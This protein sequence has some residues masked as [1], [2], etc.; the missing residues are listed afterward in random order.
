MPHARCRNLAIAL[1]ACSSA[2][3][4]FTLLGPVGVSSEGERLAL[5]GSKQ[6]ALLALLL[7]SANEVVSR[8]RLID[9]LWGEHAP[10][11]AQRS[12]DS[13]VSRLRTVVGAGRIVR[14]TPGYSIRVDAGELDLVDF[15]ALADSGRAASSKGDERTARELF[16]RALGIWSG[17]AL[18]N[19]LDEPFAGGEAERLEEA[20]SRVLE[21]R[22]RVDLD[23]GAAAEV[24]PELE[25]LV[26]AHPFREQLVLQ[27]MLALYRCGRQ[28]DALDAYQQCRRRLSDE[29]GLEPMPEL[30]ELQRRILQQDRNLAVP[31]RVLRRTMP[32][33]RVSRRRVSIAVG[34]LVAVALTVGAAVAVISSAT[35]PSS[36]RTVVESSQVAGLNPASGAVENRGVVGG[37]P[38]AMASGAGYVWLADP[39]AG[40]VSRFDPASRSV[41]DSVPVGG[42]PSTVAVGGGSVWTSSVPGNSVTRIDPA[43]GRITQRISLGSITISHLAFG[44]GGVWVGDL[45]D[46]SLIEIDPRSGEVRRTVE[47][48]LRPT[49]FGIDG[50]GIWVADYD[51]GSIARVDR[52]SGRVLATIRVGNGP[53]AFAFADRAVWVVNA[54][55]STVSRVDPQIGAVVA[56]I[57]VGSEP[58]AIVAIREKVLVANGNSGT[59]SVIDPRRNAVMRTAQLGGQPTAL[60]LAGGRA[61]VGVKPS[62]GRS[63]G[64]L[65]LVHQRPITIDPAL[66]EDLLP[67]VTDGLT[68]DGLVGFNLAPGPAGLQIV[69]DLAVTVP[70][71]TDGGRIYTFQLRPG[72]RYS[73]GRALRAADVRRAIERVFR[74]GSDNRVLFAAI[75]GARRCNVTLCDLSQGI[76]T[77]ERLRTVTFRLE[78]AD[79]DFLWKLASGAASTPVPPGT[80]DRAVGYDEPIPSTGP[81]RIASASAS[82]IRYVRNPLFKEWSHAAQPDGNPDEIV[83]RFGLTPAE[84]A[85]AIEDGRADWMADNIP[86]RLL[87][88]LRVRLPAQLH[89]F[90]IPTTDFF[91]FNATLPPFDDV[92]VRRALNLAI[93][94][95]AIARLYGGSDLATPT[96]QILAPGMTGY[97]AYCPYVG[98]SPTDRGWGPDLAKA[99]RLVAASAT[100]GTPV[101]VWGWTDDPTIRPSVTRYVAQTLRRLGYPTRVHLVPHAGL[102]STDVPRI[103]IIPTGWGRDTPYG[104]FT[105]WFTCAGDANHGW[106]C[107]R[108]IERRIELARSLA[109]T[110]PRAAA[111]AWAKIDR[112]LVDIAAALP[113]VNEHGVDFVSARVRNYQ[114]HPY[115]GVIASQL[116]LH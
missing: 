111:D 14:R 72:I 104:F 26:A 28:A 60:A 99:R 10:D 31:S 41:K 107:D 34:A 30:P 103:Q 39:S 64:T 82:E 93:D 46:S 63:G 52:R 105:R 57:P 106:L 19:V 68:R 62:A 69:P 56:T 42:A 51:V 48:P 115:Q 38:V 1:H 100:A 17:R 54:L 101:T 13:Y 76:V 112:R 50:G 110:D 11:G 84:Q 114:A 66:Q 35:G 44:G 15:R 116:S 53:A 70:V 9:G 33:V 29:L 98:R 12:L 5:G 3:V 95:R 6:H 97:R 67:L 22:I 71:T 83:M 61:W 92:R 75:R 32:P 20:R 7:L 47:L 16:G 96:C 87:P 73:D 55:D 79:P 37:A 88:S 80:P 85:R 109:A 25:A 21:D 81:Y 86:A 65:V 74:V 89:S 36:E 78:S 23:L 102:R 90:S 49:A 58:V 27:L 8:D 77:D 2:R 4:R 40:T 108:G 45:T 113:M 24:V 91:Q 18:G 59:V 94:R 43:T